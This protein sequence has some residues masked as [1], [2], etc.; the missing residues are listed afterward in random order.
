MMLWP[1][2]TLEPAPEPTPEPVPQSV[3][4]PVH[5]ADVEPALVA[6]GSKLSHEPTLGE[7][8]ENSVP[9]GAT[10]TSQA[11]SPDDAAE[12]LA[13]GLARAVSTLVNSLP[14]RRAGPGRPAADRTN[15]AWGIF[16]GGRRLLGWAGTLRWRV[17][18]STPAV[19]RLRRALAT[20][21]ERQRT[22]RLITP[23][24]EG[25]LK[26]ARRILAADTRPRFERGRRNLSW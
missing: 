1:R 19:W 9:A 12:R 7:S 22:T 21:S 15:P 14:P 17:R 6:L 10:A 16:S 11:T 18:D 2:R 13:S 8:S 25:M 3:P 23:H 24:P 4:E 5:Q 26:R 20:S